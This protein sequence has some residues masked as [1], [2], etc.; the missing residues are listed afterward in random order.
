MHTP[1]QFG[2]ATL[3]VGGWAFLARAR[4]DRSEQSDRS[5]Q[6]D[7]LQSRTPATVY[8][9]AWLVFSWL[10]LMVSSYSPARYLISSFPAMA[11][12]A[13]LALSDA[14]A[15]TDNRRRNGVL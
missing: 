6:S 12:L 15:G 13:A 9:S 2:L 11:A 7:R 4:L 3:G 1:V 10:P 5:D 8:L 14:S